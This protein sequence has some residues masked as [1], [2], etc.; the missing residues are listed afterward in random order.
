M[1][2]PVFVFVRFIWRLFDVLSLKTCDWCHVGRWALFGLS[3]GS[4]DELVRI[5]GSRL[6]M[7]PPA[8]DKARENLQC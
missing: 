1:Y 2:V 7:R 4:C 3:L 8:G 6:I 5:V